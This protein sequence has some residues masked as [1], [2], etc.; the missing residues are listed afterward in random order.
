MNATLKKSIP[1]LVL[2]AAAAG[3]YAAW[4]AWQAQHR[5][6]GLASGNGRIEATAVDVATKFAGRLDEVLVAEG[7]FVQAGQPVARMQVQSLQAQRDEAQ[8]RQQQA[9]QAQAAGQ[10][11]VALRESD[12][13]AAQALAVQRETELDAARRRLVRSE[14]LAREGASSGQELDDDRARV[15]SAQAALE[16]TRAQVKAARAAVQAA[17][18]QVTA[19]QASVQAAR[20][21]TARIDADLADGLLRAPRDARVQY[22]VAEPGEVLGAGGKVLNLVDVTDVH[23]SF[24]L[25]EA[26]AGRVALGGEVRIV[27]DAAPQLVIPA[28]VSFVAATAQFTPKTVETATER[29]KLMFRV[30]ARIDPALLQ[31]YREQ[32]KTGLPG[33]AWVRLDASRPWPARLAASVQP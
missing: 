12:A 28:R 10:A 29:Q 16:A 32:V 8:A 11:E 13:E 25:P 2:L 22:R 23:M 7:Q 31:R 21:A 3:G 27:L 33:V 9:L 5:D 17:R 1:L 18:I 14:T 26:A 4:G 20:A 19:A 24:F 30:K 15:R 6:E